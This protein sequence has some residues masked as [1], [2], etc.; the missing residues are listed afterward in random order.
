MDAQTIDPAEVI[1]RRIAL[2]ETHAEVSELETTLRGALEVASSHYIELLDEAARSGYPSPVF[3][4]GD[5]EY[6]VLTA[7]I[8]HRRHSWQRYKKTQAIVCLRPL[9]LEGR[10]RDDW[11]TLHILTPAIDLTHACCDCDNEYFVKDVFR[12][13]LFAGLLQEADRNLIC[14]F[15]AQAA[16]LLDDIATS[17]QEHLEAAREGIKAVENVHLRLSA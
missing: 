9:P 14:A 17:T 4:V 7:T 5:D 3:T 1:T 12:G 15:S 6:A 10:T 16:Q 2:E 11:R 8:K 13:S